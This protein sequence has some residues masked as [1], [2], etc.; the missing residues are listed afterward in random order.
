MRGS[1]MR[2]WARRGGDFLGYGRGAI[3]SSQVWGVLHPEVCRGFVSSRGSDVGEFE[4]VPNVFARR[5][6]IFTVFNKEAR[7]K[8]KARL[9]DELNRGYFD[10]FREMKKTGGKI[11]LASTS[12]TPVAGSP[13]F[14]SLDV[15]IPKGAALTLP[16]EDCSAALVCVAFRASAQPMVVSWSAPF[17]QK[18][19][20]STSVKVFEVSVIE[21]SLLSIWPIKPLLLRTVRGAQGTNDANELERTVV[22]AFGDTYDFRK[23]LGV[24]NLLSGYAFL[25]DRKGRVRWRAS[26]MASSEEL[27]SMALCTSRLLQEESSKAN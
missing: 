8:E 10:D 6:N 13:R 14:P 17:A 15:H 22:Y 3:A 5:L 9:Q 11:A 26:G 27:D 2:Q 7:A 21:S 12:L 1:F 24:P 18:F 4:K 23:V 25:L 16:L 19:A 20:G